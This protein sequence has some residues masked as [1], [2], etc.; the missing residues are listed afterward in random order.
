MVECLPS[1]CEALSSNPSTEKRKE[2]EEA[3]LLEKM[4]RDAEIAGLD[5][6]W[7]KGHRPLCIHL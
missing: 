1:N 5:P 4:L 7:L 2:K 6:K 3:R